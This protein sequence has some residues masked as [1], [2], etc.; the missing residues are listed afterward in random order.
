[1]ASFESVWITWPISC[2]TTAITSSSVITSIRPAQIRTLPS[3]QA[4]AFT[5]ITSYTPKLSFSPSTSLICPVSL[6]RRLPYS[7]SGLVK[8]LWASIHTIYSLLMLAMSASDKVTADTTSL[9]ACN[10]FPRLIFLPNCAE[11]VIPMPNNTKAIIAISLFIL[12]SSLM[13]YV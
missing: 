3:P 12:F 7:E 10:A 4:K 1:M 2:P 13:F 9:P 6:S 5:S 8:G 11:A